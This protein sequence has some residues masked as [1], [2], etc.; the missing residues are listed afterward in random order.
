MLITISWQPEHDKMQTVDS[1]AVEL[2]CFELWEVNEA[3]SD[4]AKDRRLRLPMDSRCVPWSQDDVRVNHGARVNW[5]APRRD[6]SRGEE[7]PFPT[8][9]LLTWVN[10]TN[11][12]DGQPPPNEADRH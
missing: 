1:V 11:P 12:V 5:W 3:P 7:P 8:V 4:D 2:S 10:E 9:Y 6:A